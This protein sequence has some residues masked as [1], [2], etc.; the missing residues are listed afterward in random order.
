[1]LEQNKEP[2]SAPIMIERPQF[3]LSLISGRSADGDAG[4]KYR[5]PKAALALLKCKICGQRGHEARKCTTPCTLCLLTK[6]KAHNRETCPWICDG[7]CD[8]VRDPHDDS[9]AAGL[10]PF[11]AC[12]RS[13]K[14]WKKWCCLCAVDAG[15]HEDLFLQMA[16]DTCRE[17]RSQILQ[18]VEEDA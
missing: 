14:L 16:C 17:R 6:P 4:P 3:M 10:D 12:K 1:M 9:S 5:T 15:M 18:G 7:G 8:I 11:R 13:N 2:K